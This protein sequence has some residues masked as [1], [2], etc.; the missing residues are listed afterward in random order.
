MNI[1]KRFI[2]NNI[3]VL[4]LTLFMMSVVNLLFMHYQFLFTIGLEAQVY[5]PRGPIDNFLACI[6]I[7]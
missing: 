1:L 3:N 4:F 2:K 6:M 7:Q 5:I